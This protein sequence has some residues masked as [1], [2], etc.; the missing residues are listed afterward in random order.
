MMKWLAALALYGVSAFAHASEGTPVTVSSAL[1]DLHTG[2]GRGYPIKISAV[3]GEQLQLLKTR[4]NWVLVEFRQ[5]QLWMNDQELANLLRLSGEPYQSLESGRA[6]F[7]KRSMEFTAFVGDLN[8]A[9]FYQFEYSYRFS[10][11]V[12]VGLSAGQANG[13]NADTQIVEGHI[14]LDPFPTW[15]VS[16]YLGIGGGMNRTTPRTV[17]VQTEDR[18][19]PIASVEVGVRYYLARNFVARAAYHRGVLA[20]SRNENDEITTWKLGFSVFF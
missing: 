13:D 7:E 16:P 14:Y 9:S 2:P 18:T 1:I 20:T 5:Q 19:D 4:G 10:D 8:G 6:A 17:L 15:Y 11:V 12:S 3:K